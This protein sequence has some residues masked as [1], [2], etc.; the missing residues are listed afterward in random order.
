M[1]RLLITATIV[2]ALAVP[3]SAV[4]TYQVY[5]EESFFGDFYEDE[6]TWL[7]TSPTFNLVLVGAYQG[8]I[9]TLTD[10]HLVVSVPEGQTGT[11]TVGGLVPI[12]AGANEDLLT[13]V[14]G[15]DAF[16]T[17]SNPPFPETFNEHYPFKDDVSDFIVYPVGDV[18]VN[19]SNFVHDYNAENGTITLSGN[20]GTEIAYPVAISGFTYAHFDLFGLVTRDND[21]SAWE[22]SPGS[23]DASFIPAPSALLL[24]GF[25]AF[26]VGW[27]RRRRFV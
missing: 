18:L 2:A 26:L 12:V 25:G 8:N 21:R 15:L 22:I 14:A 16:D 17:K 23:H 19:S 24:G 3:A 1:K 5:I 4:P 6:D 11:L 10:A 7:T 27:L 20:T 9:S 13:N